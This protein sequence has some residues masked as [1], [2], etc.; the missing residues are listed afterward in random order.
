MAEFSSQSSWYPTSSTVE[1]ADFELP[2]LVVHYWAVWNLHDRE[3]DRRLSALCNEYSDR[4]CFRSCNVDGAE[5]QRFIPDIANIPALGCFIHGELL[6]S[7]IGLRSV[8]ELRTEFGGWL[9]RFM[10]EVAQIEKRYWRVE[11]T[12]KVAVH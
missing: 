5:N 12:L 4:I 1:L 7:S 6:E 9:A 10:V 2:I 8:D 3:M 11:W